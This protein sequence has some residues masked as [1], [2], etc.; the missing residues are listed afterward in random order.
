[1]RPAARRPVIGITAY[2]RVLDV[3]TGPTLL[4]TVS[5]FYIESVERAGGLPLILPVMDPGSVE[6]SLACVHGVLLT[7]GGDVQPARYHARPT[8]DTSGVDPTR[9]AYEIRLLEVAIA[10]DVPLLA[11]C[12][13][14]QVLNVTMG[15]SLLQH[16][17]AVTGQD[18]AQYELW[19]EP[20]HRV[21][22]EPD[23]HLAE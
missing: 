21:K 12:R 5:R 20:V 11:T 15:G 1:M 7:G 9:D 6:E 18:H 4:H 13:G 22:I 8:A 14:M 19:R 10:D 23:S 2:P 16:V 17:P 3:K